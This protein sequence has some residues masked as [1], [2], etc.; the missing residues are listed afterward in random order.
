MRNAFG[1]PGGVMSIRID[2]PHQDREAYLA[3]ISL[4]AAILAAP[5]GDV[6]DLPELV[7]VP[8]L[9]S[10][11]AVVAG[12]D[13][14]SVDAHASRVLLA[15]L[16]RQRP[17]VSRLHLSPDRAV[18]LLDRLNN[19]GALE[20]ECISSRICDSAPE[21]PDESPRESVGRIRAATV[22]SARQT[23]LPVLSIGD[24]FRRSLVGIPALVYMK[25]A[26]GLESLR[27]RIHGNT[28]DD[29]RCIWVTFLVWM[30]GQL[31][32]IQGMP[33]REEIAVMID[34]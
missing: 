33:D 24:S 2:F 32:G 14:S 10:L 12:S 17:T 9:Q 13:A 6:D 3:D 34:P 4:I 1:L 20:S 19:A 11:V 22:E 18:L 29:T 15:G 16:G 8:E 31:A 28:G 30:T 21:R 25:A 26:L 27:R 5:K 7:A 23:H